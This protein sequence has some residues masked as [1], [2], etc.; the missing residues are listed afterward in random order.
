MRRSERGHW[1]R[2]W[3]G[4]RDIEEV[5]SNR[6]RIRREL[7][8]L[9]DLGGARVL[10]VGAGSGRDS[11]PLLEA[12]A[13]VYLLDYSIPSL[14]LM[15]RQLGDRRPEV[16]VL[17]G[18][19]FRLPFP[20]ATFDIVFHQGLLEHF[21]PPLPERMLREHRRVL[22]EGGLVLVDVPQRWHYYTP[23]KHV[24]ILLGRWFAGW[25]TEYSAGGLEKLVR[26]AGLEVVHT[27]GAWSSPSIPY[28]VLR[29]GLARLGVRLPMYPVRPRWLSRLEEGVLSRRFGLVTAMTIGTVGRRPVSAP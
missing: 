20:D 7:E 29:K 1:D 15:A 13:E 24:L 2:F 25:E 18:D 16:R 27:Y 5:Y 4:A 11:F 17:G 21:R 22:K 12:G 23:L 19:A 9:R 6:D 26:S 14:E 3:G 10:E 8:R 28:K